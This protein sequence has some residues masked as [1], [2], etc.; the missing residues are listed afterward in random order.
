M[1]DL[2]FSRRCTKFTKTHLRVIRAFL[3]KYSINKL[4]IIT[5]K[6]TCALRFSKKL[7]Q[8]TKEISKPHSRPVEVLSYLIR[9]D[10]VDDIRSALHSIN[11]NTRTL[12]IL[13]SNNDLTALT[14]KLAGMLPS[15]LKSQLWLTVEFNLHSIDKGNIPSQLIN[16]QNVSPSSLSYVNPFKL[17]DSMNEVLVLEDVYKRG[18]IVKS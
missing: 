7:N 13:L 10:Y 6:E 9:D 8:I 14:F 5:Q 15:L 17:V 2:S 12:V 4:A 3:K 16:I 18:V 1:D 11:I